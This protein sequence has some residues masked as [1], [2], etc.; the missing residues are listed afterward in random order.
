VL[1]EIGIFSKNYATIL[2][3]FVSALA[4]KEEDR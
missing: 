2:E 3:W 1:Q 4:A